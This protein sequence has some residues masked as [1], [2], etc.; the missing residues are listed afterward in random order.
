M[1]ANQ[2]AAAKGKIVF[3]CGTEIANQDDLCTVNGDGTGLRRLTKGS[4][5]DLWPTW[6]PNQSRV[7][8]LRG[9]PEGKDSRGN[10]DF[11]FGLY[12]VAVDGSGLRRLVKSGVN[13]HGPPS[14]SPD[15]RKLV[16]ADDDF[17]IWSVNANGTS[18]RRLT[19][20]HADDSEPSWSPDGRRIAFTRYGSGI[21]LMNSDGTSQHV[22]VGGDRF[23]YGPTWSPDGR[24]IA[25]IDSSFRLYVIN[26]NG[27]GLKV[28]A[29]DSTSPQWSPNGKT[30]LYSSSK[31]DGL[32]LTPST[33]GRRRLAARNGRSA[34]WSPDGRRIAFVRG[35]F[36]GPLFVMRADGTGKHRIASTIG[37]SDVDW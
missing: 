22:V 26:A 27:G 10:P 4:D 35:G 2:S 18:L 16:F 24:R 6:S 11:R 7:A 13:S 32:Y 19:S 9:V 37:Y 17:H 5:W 36:S 21:R 20:G 25:S 12:V 15:G 3:T 28:L 30:I 8:F 31:P 23:G 1:G 33:G 14:W 29:Y 34:A